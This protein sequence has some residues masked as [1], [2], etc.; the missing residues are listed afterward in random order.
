MASNVVAGT[1]DAAVACFE[2]EDGGK[3]RE[4]A[5]LQEVREREGDVPCEQQDSTAQS[6]PALRSTT[7]LPSLGLVKKEHQ[8]YTTP[9]HDTTPES[10]K[11]TMAAMSRVVSFTYVGSFSY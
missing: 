8:H 6:I 9:S 1:W 3:Q 5:G 4:Q 7:L 11:N 2:C 10:S